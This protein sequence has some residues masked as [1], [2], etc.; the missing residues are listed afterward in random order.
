MEE[1]DPSDE[2]LIDAT[3]GGAMW[4]LERLYQRYSGRFY[5]LACRMT[6]DHMVAE[7]L[8]QD[9]FLAVWQNG[10]SYDS[11]VGP[12]RGWLFSIIYHK[13]LNYLRDSRRS[14]TQRQVPW[15]EVEAYERFA[16]ADV[17][18][19]VWSSMQ[20]AKLHTCLMRLPTKQQVV[21]E[22]AYFEGLTQSEIAERCQIPLGT[23]KARIRLGVLHLRR[24]LEQGRKG[25]T[26]PSNHT[27]N[28]QARSRREAM[29]VVQA[30]ESGC[31]T[32]YE[33]CQDGSRRCFGYTEWE[34]LVEQIEAFEFR[35][36]TGSFTARKE[37]RAHGHTYWYAYARGSAGKRKTYLGRPPEL[38]L[39][40]LEAIA[41]KLHMSFNC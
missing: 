22:L 25:E 28:G 35:G 20:S 13:T 4:A 32:G 14:S 38:T 31:A 37:R 8:V 10:A 36:S 11:Q 5:A 33:L 16:L 19:Q 24:E 6:T 12:V 3:A 30:A 17:W 18:E 26:T 41:R 21:I 7:E 15:Q 39:P 23:V 27:D 29:V 9:A 34:R 2:F 1:D 40:H